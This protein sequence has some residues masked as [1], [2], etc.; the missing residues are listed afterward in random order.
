MKFMKR[1]FLRFHKIEFGVKWHLPP[2]TRRRND[3]IPTSMR[4]H[5][6]AS[7]WMRRHFDAMC[8]LGSFL[9]VFSDIDLIYGLHTIRACV[10]KL[11]PSTDKR[12]RINIQVILLLI[13]C[14]TTCII[15]FYFNSTSKKRVE[16]LAIPVAMVAKNDSY[17]AGKQMHAQV[18]NGGLCTG[19]G[20]IAHLD[21]NNSCKRRFP[22]CLIIGV[23]KGGTGALL[24]FLSKH[25]QIVR[26]MKIEEY[27]FF[28]EN[29]QK[30]LKW[31]RER[32]PYSLTGQIV[33]EKS[34]DYFWKP[35]VPG[36]VFKFNPNI[37]LLLIVRDPVHRAISEYAM[38]KEGYEKRN[39]SLEDLDKPFPSFEA[40]W[41]RYLRW[42]Y[43]TSIQNWLKF[44]KLEQI[45]IID[46]QKFSE[47]PVPDLKNIESFLNINHYFSD[48]L[49]VLNSTK[50]FYCF[51]ETGVP[52]GQADETNS[53][54]CLR[55]GKGRKH[56]NI[57]SS[58]IA[59]LRR[60]CRPHN[61]RFFNLT[62]RYFEWES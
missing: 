9:S 50:G 41:T 34:P 4:R 32:M 53:M 3:L 42:H 43:D 55:Q 58:F 22:N 29:Y 8:L 24:E 39:K 31:Y 7:T 40:I 36:R 15:F 20:R 47:N 37:K 59:E 10:L 57:S 51:K 26:N 49:F 61:Q 62:G 33:F 44:Y 1:A 25:P 52:V 35:Q 12:M 11:V 56:P 38:R 13:I 23:G 27:H 14:S 45:H 30:G 54:K 5:Y 46:S 2:G 19:Y 60:V 21:Y 6:V 17:T 16:F 18:M 28:S 48:E